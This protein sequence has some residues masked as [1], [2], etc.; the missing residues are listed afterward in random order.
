MRYR[1]ARISAVVVVLAVALVSACS[2]KEDPE[3]L[4]G[5]HKKYSAV[6]DMRVVVSGGVNLFQYSQRLTDSL[7]KFKNSE[8]NCEQSAAKFSAPGKRALAAEVC[9]HLDMAM[10]AYVN[11]KDFFGDAHETDHEDYFSADYM[12]GEGTYEEL[13]S[14]FPGLEEVRVALDYTRSDNPTVSRIGK[15]YWKGDML[16]ALW[17]LADRECQTAKSQIDQLSQM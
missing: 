10:N 5:L 8:D 12:F 11:S 9:R 14:R 15:V 2:K 1:L 16:Q 3:G 13:Q 4:V 6:Q 17:R 7:L